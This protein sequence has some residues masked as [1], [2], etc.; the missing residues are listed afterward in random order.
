METESLSPRPIERR[1]IRHPS[2]M[3]IRFDLQG[4]LPQRDEFLRN[5][6]EG[7]LCFATTV[8]LDPGLAIRLT[9]P[10]LGQQY[11][12]DGSVAWCRASTCGYEVGVRF[13]TPQDRF[14]VRMVEQLCYIEDYRQQVAREEGRRLSSEQAAQ[15][16]IERFA[17]QFPALH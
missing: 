14:C 17:D 7:G 13:L 3:P 8:A 15:E 10:V 16:W 5:V 11:E 4:D 1:F 6:G 2:R 12:I 9:I